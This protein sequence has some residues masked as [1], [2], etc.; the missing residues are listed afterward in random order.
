MN[1]K[2][3]FGLLVRVIISVAFAGIFYAGWMAVA[4]LVLKSGPLSAKVLC[5]MSA[6]LVTGGGFASGLAIFELL[7]GTRK[8][9]FYDIVL[10]PL[11]GCT[12]GA[13]VVVFF[14]P[15]LIVF[16]MFAVGAASILAKEIVSIKKAG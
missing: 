10:W 3:L 16:G 5:W 9:K 1:I 8:S 7:P 13:I 2:C 4:I 12:I 15:M 6:P 11:A 14:G